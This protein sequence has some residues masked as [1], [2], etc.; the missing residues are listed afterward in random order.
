MRILLLAEESA[1]LRAL[2]MIAARDDELVAVV[3]SSSQDSGQSSTI[4]KTALRLG[5]DVWHPTDTQDAEFG[6]KI[7][8]LDIDILLNVHSLY[9]LDASVIDSPKIGSF[10]LHPGPLPQLAGLN[11]PSWAI[12]LGEKRHA[13]T[14]HW[15][16]AGIDTGPVAYSANF[17]LC[18]HDTGLSVSNACVKLGIPL[19]G[20]LLDTATSDHTAIPARAQDLKYRRVFGRREIPND[21]RVDWS[22]SARQIDAFVRAADYGPFHSP[23]GHPKTLADGRELAIVKAAM[24]GQ[25]TNA[26]PGHVVWMEADGVGVAA[27]DQIVL[28]QSIKVDDRPGDVSKLIEVGDVLC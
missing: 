14:L 6:K 22:E 13:V 9:V 3:T 8:D 16:H 27:A 12:Y 11:A 23:W 5:C 20:K 4:R 17:D 18:D 7:R 2:R 19:I 15:M 26:T 1:G 25:T 28:V 10:N 21:G 24:T